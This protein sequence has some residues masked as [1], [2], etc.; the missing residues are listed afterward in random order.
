MAGLF[1]SFLHP[2]GSSSLPSEGWPT[3]EVRETLEIPRS[4]E[5]LWRE[6]QGQST[7]C[8]LGQGK[9]RRG[10]LPCRHPPGAQTRTGFPRSGC[11][12]GLWNLTSPIR[13]APGGPSNRDSTPT[14]AQCMLA[15][16]V[17]VATARQGV[18]R[19]GGGAGSTAARIGA[20]SVFEVHLARVPALSLPRVLGTGLPDSRQTLVFPPQSRRRNTLR[21]VRRGLLC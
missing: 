20:A 14:P 4:W 15:F 18:V 19:N 1:L 11:C 5:F 2:P 17:S 9:A 12:V 8:R 7:A 6:G 16:P 21:P 10:G 13:A 3:A